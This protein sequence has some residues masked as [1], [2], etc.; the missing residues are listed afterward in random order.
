MS[1]YIYIYHPL[2][3]YSKYHNVQRPALLSP[4]QGKSTHLK[5]SHFQDEGFF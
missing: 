1:V 2:N 4:T 3:I 5:R